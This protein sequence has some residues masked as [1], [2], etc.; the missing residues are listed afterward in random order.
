MPKNKELTGLQN[1]YISKKIHHER[2]ERTC[3]DHI[4]RL[5]WLR[6]GAPHSVP[7]F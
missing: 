3:K 7:K 5:A 1:D 6:D 4:Q 2:V